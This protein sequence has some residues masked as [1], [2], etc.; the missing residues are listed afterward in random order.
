MKI[1]N[2]NFDFE[3]R[4]AEGDDG[5]NK[6]EGYSAVFNKLSNPM[7]GFREKIKPGAFK[8]TIKNDDVRALWNHDTSKV[9][10]RTKNNTLKLEEDEKGLKINIE[11]PETSWANDVMTSIKREDVDQ[12]SFGFNV[13]EDEWDQNDK[14]NII[15]TLTKVKLFEVSPVTFPAYPQTNVQARELLREQG[16]N[17]D[18]LT[19]I[20]YRL[21]CG[22]ELT[23]TDRNYINS[24]IKKL[25]SYLAESDANGKNRSEPDK[26]QEG[27]SSH[28]M[29][30]NK[31]LIAEKEIKQLER[32]IN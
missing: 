25:E 12:M 29:R 14:E 31:L 3:L 19:G 13:L 2:N 22:Q 21:Q 7:F 11:P 24:T 28:L 32:M 1:G 15:R 18:E 16:I 10:G 4:S 8:E 27:E 6:I 30:R 9:L 17:F 20:F 23:K 5:N 26:S